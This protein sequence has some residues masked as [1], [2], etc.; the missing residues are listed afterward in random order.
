MS[1][2]VCRAGGGTNMFQEAF[3]RM[4]KVTTASAPSTMKITGGAKHLHSSSRVARCLMLLDFQFRF[5]E[6][7][8]SC[9]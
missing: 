4:T 7:R 8:P 2:V 5:A 3:E 6:M 1:T 9:L